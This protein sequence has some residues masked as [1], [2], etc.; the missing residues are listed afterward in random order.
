MD[1][2]PTPRRAA[3]HFI[4]PVWGA[5]Y[6][7]LFTDVCLPMIL[8]PGNL[9]AM[10]K[11]RDRFVIVTTWKDSIAIRR[12]RAF[13]QLEAS[14][15]I[16]ILLIDGLLD[17]SNAHSAM[18]KCYGMAMQLATVQPGITNFVFLTPDS[19]WSDGAF[20]TLIDLTARGV[21]VVMVAGLRVEAEA[22]STELRRAIDQSP[23]NPA[24]TRSDL[25]RLI[26]ANLHQLSQAHNWLSRDRFLNVWPSHIY[27]IDE[28]NEQLVAHCFH[29]HPLL[30][31]APRR[32]AKIGTTIDGDFLDNLDIPIDRY[33]V[34]QGEFLG[35]EL[36]PA[37]RN[38]GQPLGQPLLGAV[39]RFGL[40]N[41]NAKHWQFFRRRIVIGTERNARVNPEL[42]RLASVIV[43][44]VLQ[45]E[46]YALLIQKFRL[47]RLVRRFVLSRN[48]RFKELAGRVLLP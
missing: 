29:M 32:Q 33:H 45:V 28:G 35:V 31:R 18:S 26:L 25:V 40:F 8:T 21:E 17:T 48:R 15:Q 41:A 20:S 19:F 2:G 14:L 44:K 6:T 9:G 12:S 10:D 16:D 5:T 4:V 47:G 43:E 38:W 39:R 13:L 36:S 7:T 3:F 46:R 30:V 27:W 37:E 1:R 11:N 24:L 22:V 23:S 34:V 42:E